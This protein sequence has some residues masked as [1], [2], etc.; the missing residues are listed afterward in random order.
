VTI[1]AQVVKGQSLPVAQPT[2]SELLKKLKELTPNR[3]SSVAFHP[4][5]IRQTN[6]K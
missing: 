5:S 4:F 1:D 3:K 6:P 2:L